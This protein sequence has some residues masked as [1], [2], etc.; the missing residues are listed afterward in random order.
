VRMEMYG[1]HAGAIVALLYLPVVGVAAVFAIDRSAAAGWSPA[2]RFVAGFERASRARRVVALLLAISAAIHLGLVPAHAEENRTLAALFVLDFMA[3]TA[4]AVTAFDARIPNWRAA[5]ASLLVANLIAYAVYVVAGAETL[6]A[7][8]IATKAVELAAL[9]LVIHPAT[10]FVGMVERGNRRRDTH[11]RTEDLAMNVS[12]TYALAFGAVY[13]LVG[14]IG[15]AVAPTMQTHD[16]II[17]PVNAV[18]NAVHLAVGLV[19]LAAF[20][21]ARDVVYGRGMAILFAVLTVA[22]FLPQPLLGLVPLGGWDIA[23]HAATALLGGVAGFL[24]AA[25]ARTRASI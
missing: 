22:G 5:A 4:T 2:L 1:D 18:H 3:L 7:V 9:I 13:T 11:H 8:G 14:I 6:D 12:R 23:L 20:F 21:T 24:Y 17:F 10:A 15:F 19:G 25:P 16:L